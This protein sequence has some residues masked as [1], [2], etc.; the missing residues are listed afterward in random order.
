MLLLF[1]IIQPGAFINYEIIYKYEKWVE[2][3]KNGAT[4]ITK[5]YR[6]ILGFKLQIYLCDTHRIM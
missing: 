3:K 2:K 5:I 4:N 6:K 1:N